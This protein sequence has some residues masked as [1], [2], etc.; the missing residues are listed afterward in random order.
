MPAGVTTSFK[1]ISV[2]TIQ[3]IERYCVVPITLAHGADSLYV[4]TLLGRSIETG[5][6][7]AGDYSA[8]S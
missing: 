3:A 1:H 2:L 7:F 5:G 6:V 8:Q 4:H